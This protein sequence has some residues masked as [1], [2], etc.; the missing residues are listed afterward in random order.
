MFRRC[1]ET[2]RRPAPHDPLGFIQEFE[3]QSRWFD[4]ASAMAWLVIVA[5]AIAVWVV[6]HAPALI[7][8]GH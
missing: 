6:A 7:H 2:R 4:F 1:R 8:G 3:R 5:T